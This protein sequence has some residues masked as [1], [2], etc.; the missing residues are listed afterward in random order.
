[1]KNEDGNDK[2]KTKKKQKK[3]MGLKWQQKTK[4]VIKGIKNKKEGKVNF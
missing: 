4:K 3:T 2:K 1:M